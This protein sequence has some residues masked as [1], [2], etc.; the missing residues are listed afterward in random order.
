MLIGADAD[1]ESA[2]KEFPSQF[3]DIKDGKVNFKKVEKIGK[4]TQKILIV[5]KILP[6]TLALRIPQ[7]RCR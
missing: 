5:F 7:G 3:D 2:K 1:D 4:I 6:F